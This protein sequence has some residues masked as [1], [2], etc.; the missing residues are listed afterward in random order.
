LLP[1]R[2]RLFAKDFILD[3]VEAS[4]GKKLFYYTVHNRATGEIVSLGHESSYERAHA[5][6]LYTFRHLTGEDLEFEQAK[7]QSSAAS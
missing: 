3:I 7:D 6:A 4:Y 1:N 5:A 2:T